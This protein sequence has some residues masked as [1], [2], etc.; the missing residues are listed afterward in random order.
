MNALFKPA[1]TQASKR[2]LLAA[3]FLTLTIII[4]LA[5]QVRWQHQR[6]L[7]SQQLVAHTLEV[8]AQTSDL[9]LIAIDGVSSMRGYLLSSG[10]EAFLGPYLTMRETLFQRFDQ[11]SA[12]TADN[13]VQQGHMK[14]LQPLLQQRVDESNLHYQL[15]QQQGVSAAMARLALGHGLR[16]NIQLRQLIEQIHQEENRLLK[17]RE[18]SLQEQARSSLQINT[19][20]IGLFVLLSLL[21][22]WSLLRE[23]RQR[24]QH[25]QEREL[26]NAELDSRNAN[27]QA[28]NETLQQVDQLK[29]EFLSAMSH[30]L[31][32]PLNSIIGFTGLLRMG[33]PGP[34]NDEQH[35]Q[36][37]LVDDSAK[38]LL[39]LINDLLDLSRIEAGRAEL[40]LENFDFHSIVQDTFATV[41]PMVK[42]KGL[43]LATDCRAGEV[44]L[45][46][47]RRKVY[48]VLL[49][50]VNNAVKFSS[51]GTINVSCQRHPHEYQISVSDQGIGIRPEQMDL[52]FQAFRQVDGSARRV[53]EG[54]GLGLYLSKKLLTMLGGSIWAESRFGE[55]SRFIFSLPQA[56]KD[57]DV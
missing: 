17:L 47:D 6:L 11:L 55:G 30:E 23:W 37:T 1:K 13:P 29:N 4:W 41:A 24:T 51:Q 48:Q 3:G 8:Q 19:L 36:L 39:H 46:S 53:Y 7:D 27:L 2:K 10:D 12:L 18:A 50:L 56:V 26:L 44:V 15:F 28:A 35:K 14:L 31:R 32:T 49:N 45:Y 38:H 5:L 34:L 57:E 9:L 25:D 16:I 52:L 22:L 43:N 33:I 54:T 42:Q 21:M 20:L 40:E